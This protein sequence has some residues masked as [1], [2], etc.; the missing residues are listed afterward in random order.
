MAGGEIVLDEA[1]VEAVRA[2]DLLNERLAEAR[3][4][5]KGSALGWLF[6]SKQA[7]A[8]V[9][10]LYIYGEVGRGKTMLMNS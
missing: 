6:A 2:F 10:G 8:P 9:R 3:L 4:A 5:R 1:Q 7:T